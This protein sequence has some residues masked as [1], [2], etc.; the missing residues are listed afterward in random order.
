VVCW[1]DTPVPH[2]GAGVGVPC[3]DLDV[4]QVDAGVEHRGDEGVPEHVW[5]HPWQVRAGALRKAAQP[6]GG[7]V[8]VH[9]GAA[10]VQQ[11]R[12]GSAVVDCAVDGAG[13]GRW[14][15]NEDG[16]GA[17]ADHTQDTVAVFFAEVGDVAAGGLEDP[18]PKEPSIATRRRR[19]G[20]RKDGRPSAGPVS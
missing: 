3:G 14:E 10:A 15:G 20:S 19:C 17:L 5:V 11:D 2:G 1:R 9:P 6:A 18:Q 8:A 13:Y 7:R 12:T 4:A 16:L